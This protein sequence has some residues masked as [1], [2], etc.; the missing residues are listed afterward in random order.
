MSIPADVRAEAE[1]V[2]ADFC[3][4]HSSAVVSDQLRYGY[5]V[6]ASAVV[7]QAQRPGF[8]NPDEWT[9][10]PVAKLRYSEAR[11]TWSLYWSDANG[12]WH[13]MGSVPMDKDIR[14]LLKAIETDASGVF[15]GK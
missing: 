4:S 3:R 15:W 6:V 2:L 7:L 11:Q 13:R 1:A 10:V 14:V 12:R 9:S 8:M 5:E